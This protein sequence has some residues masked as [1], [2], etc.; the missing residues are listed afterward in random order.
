MCEHKFVNVAEGNLITGNHFHLYQ[1]TSCG[2]FDFGIE[3]E[4][5]RV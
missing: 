4:I 1:C 5:R 2:R 3:N